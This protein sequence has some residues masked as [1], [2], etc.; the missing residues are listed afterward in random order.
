MKVMIT[1]ITGFAGPHLA[2]LLL[3]EG[4]EIDGLIRGS[5]GRECDLLDVMSPENLERIRFHYGD[6]KDYQS[7]SKIF[8]KNKF[9][10]VFH[11]AAQS[12]PPTSFIDPVG[13]MESNVMGSANLIDVIQRHQ[14]ECILQFTS[15]S[16]VY[17][18]QGKDV[19]VLTEDLALKPSNPYGT[20][21]AAIDLY[22]QERCKNRF[23]RGF[24]TRA[25]SHTGTRRG[26]NFSISCDAYN[27][28]LMK[29]DP[30]K[31][32]ELPVGNLK[33]KRIVMD[34]KDCVGA[35]YGIMLKFDETVNG[36]AYNV[37]GAKED[38]REM[39][40]FTDT[41]IEISGLEGV[42][43]K[44]DPRFFRPID[45]QIQVGDTVKLKKLTGWTPTSPLNETLKDLFNYWY[46]KIQQV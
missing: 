3:K 7:L 45:I 41:L 36:Q 46:R 1:G 37:C 33:T 28:A 20:S 35:Y 4:H 18:D 17:G 29:K 6:L 8:T 12:H 19:G 5:N 22:V 14:P 38:L 39:E 24:I 26:K 25:F 23:L 43:K 31:S 21:K 13:T 15:T 34:V 32:R 40:F 27:L 30:T 9:D 10:G 11:L 44:I 42:V 2:N 16:E